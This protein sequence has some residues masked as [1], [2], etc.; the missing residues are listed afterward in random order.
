MEDCPCL[1]REGSKN[2]DLKNDWWSN[3]SLQF[4]P[5]VKVWVA[6]LHLMW[7][8]LLGCQNPVHDHGSAW[9]IRRMSASSKC[10]FFCW[11]QQKWVFFYSS[12]ARHVFLLP[13]TGSQARGQPCL[14]GR[15]DSCQTAPG[16]TSNP[17]Q[18]QP[19]LPLTH[20]KTSQSFLCLLVSLTEAVV[21]I[22]QH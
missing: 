13:A 7:K 1:M 16:P 17:C 3:L 9:M 18:P 22:N 15:C 21:K 11:W 10:Q 8:P 5:S 19:Q 20:S 12:C 4:A 6:S 14:A 2:G